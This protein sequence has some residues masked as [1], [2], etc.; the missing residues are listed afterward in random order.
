VSDTDDSDELTPAEQALQERLREL[1]ADQATPSSLTPRI[2]RAAR[3][4]R[5]LRRPLQAIGNIGGAVIDGVRLLLGGRT[6]T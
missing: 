5:T 4:Q 6:R 2:V 1:Q 3:W